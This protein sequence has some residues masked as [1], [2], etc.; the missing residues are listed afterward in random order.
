MFLSSTFF[1][2]FKSGIL[3]SVFFTITISFPRQFSNLRPLTSTIAPSQVWRN[4]VSIV[5]AQGENIH[6]I[7]RANVEG[8]FIRN[9]IVTTCI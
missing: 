2:Y 4:Y 5:G 9:Q 1:L 8:Y 6:T 7:S 3:I